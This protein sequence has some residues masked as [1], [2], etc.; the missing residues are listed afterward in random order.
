MSKK[1]ASSSLSSSL[2]LP[3]VGA[4]SLAPWG[5]FNFNFN[6]LHLLFD[7]LSEACNIYPSTFYRLFVAAQDTEGESSF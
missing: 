4:L 6:S 2:S 5:M 1:R 3:G 7:H